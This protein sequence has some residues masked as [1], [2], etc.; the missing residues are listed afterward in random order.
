MVLA[1]DGGPSRSGPAKAATVPHAHPRCG[2]GLHLK[3]GRSYLCRRTH[4]RIQD[5]V[6][7]RMLEPL[8]HP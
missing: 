1:G 6:M 3:L 4:A 5:V 7:L 2:Q 8:C